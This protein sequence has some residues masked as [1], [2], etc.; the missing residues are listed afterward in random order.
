[1]NSHLSAGTRAGLRQQ[2]A[3]KRNVIRDGRILDNAELGPDGRAHTFSEL[4]FLLF[5]DVH[6]GRELARFA[7]GIA[8]LPELRESRRRRDEQDDG[9]RRCFHDG[10]TSEGFW[11]G[12]ERRLRKWPPVGSSLD[13]DVPESP[14]GV[15]VLQSSPGGVANDNPR[16]KVLVQRLQPRPQVH[17]V[18]DDRVAHDRPR[19]D[20]AGDHL[21]RIHADTDIEGTFPS[22]CHLRL[23]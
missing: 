20:V 13:G 7:G 10:L 9:K 16:A 12:D 23:S 15:V 22:A 11:I 19:A 14:D 17:V 5:R 2:I 6:L 18:A 4:P 8:E 3:E 1:M 21:P